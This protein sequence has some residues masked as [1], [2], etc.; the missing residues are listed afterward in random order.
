[1]LEPDLHTFL[2]NDAG[3]AALVADGNGARITPLLLPESSALPAVTYHLVSQKREQTFAHPRGLVRSWLQIDCWGRNYGD[4]KSLAEA[5]RVALDNF[6]GTMGTSPGTTVQLAQLT[7]ETDTYAGEP[8]IYR[9]LMEF[10]IW[11]VES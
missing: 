3:V 9:V 2:A 1:M 6:A 5:V 7:S 11:F 8:R 10:W 4:A